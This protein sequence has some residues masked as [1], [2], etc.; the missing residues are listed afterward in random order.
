MD[1]RGFASGPI[2]LGTKSNV[3]RFL[4]NRCMFSLEYDVSNLP[5][6]DIM[7]SDL[8]KAKELYLEALDTKARLSL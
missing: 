4:E 8:K 7:F 2:D 5:A 1:S 6:D 3:G